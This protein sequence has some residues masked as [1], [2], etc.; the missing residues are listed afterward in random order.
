VEFDPITVKMVEDT[1]GL[2]GQRRRLSA[3]G[4]IE[5][6]C[7]RLS[8]GENMLS[9]TNDPTMPSTFSIYTRMARD[10]SLQLQISRARAAGAEAL[11]EQT[12]AL[13]D[14]ATPD[15]WQVRKLQV[16][17][18][19]WYMGKVAPKKYGPPKESDTEPNTLRVVI[20]G[21]L[22]QD[23]PPTL[24]LQAVTAPSDVSASD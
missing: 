23:E 11:A 17:G 7:N 3:P 22:P 18:R 8:A 1:I 21:G 12:L 4:V 16:W 14:S 15:N 9:I 19:Q 10:E 20:E 13:I 24:E 5:E 6:I 2:M